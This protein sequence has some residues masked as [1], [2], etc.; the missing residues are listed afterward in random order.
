LVLATITPLAC[1]TSAA[2]GLTIG[3][4][5]E[6]R[7]VPLLASFIALPLGFFGAIFY[8]W[9]ALQPIPWLKYLVLINPLVYMSEGF[10]AGLSIGV[11]HMPVS[12]IYLALSS[13]A[14]LFTY[15]GVTGFKKR[16]LS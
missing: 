16:V 1:Y 11:V 9:D 10:R 5:L 15:L 13:F 7:L 8:T 12:V 14:V 2:I 3:T 6:P 4:R